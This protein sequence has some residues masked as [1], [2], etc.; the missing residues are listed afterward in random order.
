MLINSIFPEF[1]IH[2]PIKLIFNRTTDKQIGTIN[3]YKKKRVCKCLYS[4]PYLRVYNPNQRDNVLKHV[5]HAIKPMLRI[6]F[7]KFWFA[8]VSYHLAAIMGSI[9]PHTPLQH[10]DKYNHWKWVI[11][12]C[13]FFFVLFYLFFFYFQNEY[14]KLE[15]FV[16]DSFDIFIPTCVYVFD[17]MKTNHL[18]LFFSFFFLSEMTK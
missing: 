17:R 13:L 14:I 1:E 9:I 2:Y 10:S 4:C 8:N 5:F 16:S 12:L 18:F 3:K 6:I 7:R 15:Y 11:V